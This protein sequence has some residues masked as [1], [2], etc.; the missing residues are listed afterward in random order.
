MKIISHRGN[1][2]GPNPETENTEE[3]IEYALERGFEVEIDLWYDS[4]KFW[5][6]HDGPRYDFSLD[7]LQIWSIIANIYVHCKNVSAL[8]LM[9]EL[10]FID[11]TIFPIL[12][13]FLDIDSCILLG[14]NYIWVHP[15][16][17]NDVDINHLEKCIAVLPKCKSIHADINLKNWGGICTDY[18]EDVRNNLL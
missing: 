10:D 3:A 13:F 12:P 11:H 17:V 9:M 15:N 5:L 6:G 8:Q 1:L 2:W 4:G 16:N 14:N 7:K 18:P